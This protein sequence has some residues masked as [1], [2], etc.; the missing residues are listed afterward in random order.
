MQRSGAATGESSVAS[1]RDSGRGNIRGNI[2]IVNHVQSVQIR[3]RIGRSGR[4]GRI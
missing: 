2:Q 3:G 1:L 4:M